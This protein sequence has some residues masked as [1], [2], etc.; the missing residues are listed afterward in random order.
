[1]YLHVPFKALGVVQ[2]ATLRTILNDH[3]HSITFSNA[4]VS[5]VKNSNTKGFQVP[6]GE[7]IPLADVPDLAW[8]TPERKPLEGPNHHLALDM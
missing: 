6:A 1:M 8:K 4:A 5:R 3:L 2:D 7:F